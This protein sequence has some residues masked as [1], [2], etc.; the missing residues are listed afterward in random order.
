MDRNVIDSDAIAAATP[1]LRVEGLCK[2]FALPGGSIVKACD[3]ISLTVDEGQSLGIVGESGSGKTT[4]MKMLMQ[5]IPASSGTIYFQGH[6]IDC[7]NKSQQLEYHQHIQMVFQD[8]TSAFNP[9]MKVADSLC[10]PLYNQGLLKGRDSVEVAATYLDM[11]ELSKDIAYRYPHELS[12]G[13]RQRIAIARALVAHPDIIIFDEATSALDVSV[14]DTIA[15]LLVKLQKEHGYTYIFVA[16]DIAFVRC[17]CHKV[18]VMHKGKLVDY[19]AADTLVQSDN[20][21]TRR[22]IQSVYEI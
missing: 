13:Q 22:L 18:A 17:I 2:S 9:R 4:L 10:E 20:P 19:L 21:Y 3:S 15:R 11:V 16:H 1:L 12:G 5:L 7:R 14:Q 6:A 8:S